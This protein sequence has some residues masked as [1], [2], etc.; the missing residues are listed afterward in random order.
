MRFAATH[1]AV[2]YLMVTTAF[3]MLALTGEL[4]I[5]LTLLTSA[6]IVGSF[7][8]DPQNQPWMMRR[9]YSYAWWALLLLVLGLLL[10]DGIRG[11]SIWEGGSRFLCVF[12]LAKLWQRR[13]NSDYL[14][15]YVAS[16]LM[17]LSASLLGTSMVY[18]VCL[19]F[20]IVFSTWTLT[21]F[22]LRR[23]MEE[24]YLLKHLP[25]KNGQ[26]AESERVEVERILNSRRV[27]G[28]SFLVASGLVSV[29]IFLLA[30]LLFLLLPR[31][32]ISL[33]LPVRRKGLLLTGF[34][35][36]IKLG[37]HGLLREN[38]KV[39]MR[40]QLPGQ[41]LPPDLRFRGISF[42]H[43]EHGQWQ[44]THSTDDHREPTPGGLY[45][46][47]RDATVQTPQDASVL[48][49]EIY[50]EP[51][52]TS[53]LFVPAPAKTLAVQLPDSWLS[54]SQWP[55]QFGGDDDL[56]AKN[57]H[58][59]LHYTVYSQRL[60]AA[61]ASGSFRTAVAPLLTPSERQQ[62]LQL[63][64]DLPPSIGQLAKERTQGL[65][66]PQDQA[67]ALVAFLQKDF[68][69]TTQLAQP[70]HAE[71]L[72]DFLFEQKKG[73]CEY[74]ATALTI[75]LRRLGIP[76]RSINGYLGGE[77]NAYGGYLIVRQQHA[78]SWVEAYLPERGWVTL[79]PTPQAGPQPPRTGI[80]HWLGQFSDDLE[81]TFYKYVIEYDLRSQLQ[82]AAKFRR[83]LWPQPTVH[84]D[85]PSA[86]YPLRRW[87][88]WLGFGAAIL[89]IL[90]MSRRLW[91]LLARHQSVEER[92]EEQAKGQL[93]RALQVLKRR[94]F[95]LRPAET[96]QQLAA[97]VDLAGDKSAA[98]FAELV[99][100][101]YAHR[102]GQQTIDLSEVTRLTRTMARAPRSSSAIPVGPL[103]AAPEKS[104]PDGG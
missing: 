100:R 42:D 10:P 87:G 18:A 8:F 50:L 86:T 34:S 104:N 15:A 79:D 73:H 84:S 32:G 89:L 66:R 76:A 72:Q 35:E 77:W 55:L 91:R 28:T 95:V 46:L 92:T 41:T 25:G 101:Y 56:V 30:D 19:L 7:F 26:A 82:L 69:Y 24:N 38:A 9:A 33:D 67:T 23:E 75:M 53:V 68:A 51:L 57:R 94:G 6:G 43:Y 80:L 36:H 61:S 22:H 27:V 70:K 37:A 13:S 63:P 40:V 60:P 52:E 59:S 45:L 12:L 2:S 58:G 21:L 74:F 3:I 65:S 103:S 98:S 62:Y 64:A 85:S 31:V 11:D 49:S 14:Q 78:H 102:F 29:G 81:L 99:Q 47:G 1:K 96:L 20:Y 97:R 4:P 88:R 90:L 83:T 17:L 54:T 48:R 39:V 5:L 93:R 71:P 44:K 16:F